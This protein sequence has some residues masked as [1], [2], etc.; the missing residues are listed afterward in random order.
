MQ[1]PNRTR[2]PRLFI[3]A[4]LAAGC[5]PAAPVEPTATGKPLE[6]QSFAVGCA[7]PALA[8]LLSAR[9]AGFAA[10]TGAGATAGPAATADLVVIRP[11]E[12]GALAAA[13]ELLPLPAGLRTSSHPLRRPGVIEVYRDALTGWGGNA[14]ALPVAGDGFVLVTRRDLLLDERVRDGVNRARGREPSPPGTYEEWAELAGLVAAATGRPAYPALPPDDATLVADFH[15]VAACYDRPAAVTRGGAEAGPP[16][17]AFDYSVE[18][19]Q[20]RLTTPGFVRAAEYLARAQKLRPAGTAT[21]PEALEA[22]AVSAILS[23]RD[24]AR[25]PREGSAVAARYAVSP[26]PGTRTA[27]GAGGQESP[28]VGG[29]FVPYVGAGTWVAAVRKTAKH[30]DAAWAFAAELA[31][32]GSRSTLADPSAGAGPFRREDLEASRESVLLSYRLSETETKNLADALRAGIAVNV[33]NP[34]TVRRTPDQAARLTELAKQLRRVAAGEVAPAAGLAA[35]EAAWRAR[36]AA[37]PPGVA[38][39]WKR[40]AANVP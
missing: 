20:P 14:V 11:A 18:T 32:P 31:G 12:L 16:A 15:R 25:L 4:L 13:G 3:F 40:N 7:D 35:A 23:L 17:L 33:V 39:A 24:V 2:P 1:R 34:A 10:A 26:L 28:T 9:A 8:R 6:G 37:L 19:L 22:G 5:A 36:D 29:N 38:A 21:P 30:P 27:F